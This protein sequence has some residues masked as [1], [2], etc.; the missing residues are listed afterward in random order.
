MNNA[1]KSIAASLAG[2][3][4]VASATYLFD[5]ENGRQRRSELSDR[6]RSAAARFN[7]R[8]RVV[9][10]DLSHRYHALSARA[11]SWFERDST[12][13]AALAKRVRTALWRAMP[14]AAKVGVVAHHGQVILH[15]DV[16]AHEHERV[17]QIARA[18]DGVA[19]IVD[20]MLDSA[21]SST[22]LQPAGARLQRRLALLRDDLTQEHW[23]PSTRVLSGVVGGSLLRW[24]AQHR[25]VYGVLG[26]LAG[27]ALV[28]RSATNMSWRRMVH[29]REAHRIEGPTTLETASNSG[30]SGDGNARAT[31]TH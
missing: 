22:S 23:S 20:H 13:D 29:M 31:G 14:N 19:S 27:A 10:D 3:A 9:G 26:A 30:L 21:E 15:G 6:C 12:S 7:E 1:T 16:L 4:V 18:V 28:F 17:L 5:P 2:I 24:G 11:Q 8:R 25:D